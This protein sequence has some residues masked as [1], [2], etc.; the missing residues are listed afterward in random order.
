MNQLDMFPETIRLQCID[1]A[2]NKR[3]FYVMAVQPT[4]FGEWEL[5]R[6]W[7][8]IGRAGRVRHDAFRSAGEA[9]DA[10]AKLA[11]QKGQRGYRTH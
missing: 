11:K 9:L 4:L 3:R 5:M 8:R 2:Q 1:P 6:E 10:M 7:G